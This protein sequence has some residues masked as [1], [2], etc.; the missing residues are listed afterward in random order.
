MQVFENIDYAGG[1]SD[2]YHQ[3]D[4]LVPSAAVSRCGPLLVF[5]HG[6]AWRSEDKN[7]HR[8]LANA[9]ALLTGCSI[10]VPNYRLTVRD[11]PDGEIVR[12]PGH[13]QDL[14]HCLHFL[15]TWEGPTPVGRAY[16]PHRL[17]LVGHSCSAHMLTCIFLDSVSITP[18][19]A[20]SPELLRA[21]QA[22]IM[23]EGIYDIDLLLAHFPSYR[24]WFVQSTFERAS[25]YDEYST[26]KLALRS[27]HMRW[28]VI[29]SKGD[30]LID[31]PQSGAMYNHLCSLYGE[32]A[33]THV[34][35]NFDQLDAEHNDILRGDA[36][37]QLVG[38]FILKDMQSA[39]V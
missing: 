22:I 37:P 2:I 9:L 17:Y 29:H 4:L 27:S 24:E 21:V 30:T 15:L 5:V 34:H 8:S 7:D 3:F 31:L 12:H 20:P 33:V 11:A 19:L 10:A 26:T 13:T 36:Y 38:N 14:L 6:G 39:S 35:R 25:S 23:S 32:N 28:L 1:G 18:S 16:D